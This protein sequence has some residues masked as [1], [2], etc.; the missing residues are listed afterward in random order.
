MQDHCE[1]KRDQN[2]SRRQILAVAG[3]VALGL[4]AFAPAAQALAGRPATWRSFV[5]FLHQGFLV[6]DAGGDAVLILVAI[7]RS[8]RGRR[9]AHLP[10]PFSLIFHSATEGAPLPSQTY[11][12]ETPGGTRVAMFLSQITGDSSYYEAPFN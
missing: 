3:S 6:S 9:P 2:A 7:E 11:E 10:D 1:P 4:T 12:V 5:P 8:P